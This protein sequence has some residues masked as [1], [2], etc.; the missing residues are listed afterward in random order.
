MPV[1]PISLQVFR[2]LFASVAEEMGV[3]LGRTAYSANIKERLDYSCALFDPQGRMV[4]QAA[5]IPVHL[6]SMPASVHAALER[7]TLSS[8]DVVILNDPYMGGTHLPDI[9]LVAPVF[10][11]TPAGRVLVGFVA[12]RGHH[13]DIGGMTPGSLPLSTDLFQEGLIIPPLKLVR[14]GRINQEVVELLCRNSRTPDDR[15]G[16]LA[17]QLAAYRVGERRLQ[18]IVARYGWEE[19]QAHMAAILDYSERLTRAAIGGIP[20]G[21]YTARD[22]L[23]DDGLTG[24][25][26][27]IQVAVRVRGEEMEV[28]FTGT[29]PQ[30][31]GCVNAPFAVTLSAVMYTVL[32]IAGEQA[33]PNEGVMRSIRVDAPVGCLIN[34]TPPHAVAGGNVETSQ[35]IV[36]VLFAALAQAL[37]HRIPAAS[38]GT[39][40]NVLVGGHDPLRDKGFAYYETIGGGMGARPGKDGLSGVHT[41]MTNTMNTPIEALELQFPMRIRRY[42]LRRGSGGGGRRRGGDGIVRDMEFLAPATVTILSERRKSVPYGLQGGQPGESGENVLYKGGVEE[43]PL[44]AKVTFEA[45]AGDVLSIRTPGGGGW[46]EEEPS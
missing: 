1:D 43:V 9:T 30:T 31:P 19:T 5:H 35:R 4:A 46:G 38:Q 44:S 36:D 22:F 15:R 28:D 18:E 37:P 41:H 11:P 16:D 6:G 25:P 13:A 45:E 29:A 42:T 7:F 33:P 34:P 17:A 14:R 32:C 20:D 23:D 27:L 12:N 8:G 21:V 3:V 2:N 39:M 26:L 24:Q 40:N 10:A